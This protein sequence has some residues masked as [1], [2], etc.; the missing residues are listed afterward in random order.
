M[1]GRGVQGLTNRGQHAEKGKSE[2][3]ASH[4]SDEG[5]L[6]FTVRVFVRAG[7]SDL[8]TLDVIS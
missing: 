8:R 2:S 1:G 4:S 5:G 7:E 6:K 3:Q